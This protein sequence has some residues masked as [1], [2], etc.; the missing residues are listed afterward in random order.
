MRIS[1]VIQ[2]VYEDDPI[3]RGTPRVQGG[4]RQEAGRLARHRRILQEGGGRVGQG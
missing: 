4:Y 2:H 3:A 1:G